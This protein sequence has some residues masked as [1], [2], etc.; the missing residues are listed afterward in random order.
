MTSDYMLKDA[1]FPAKLQS[2]VQEPYKFIIKKKEKK[3]ISLKAA[4]L[5]HKN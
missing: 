2:T 3:I 4:I 1:S 5:G